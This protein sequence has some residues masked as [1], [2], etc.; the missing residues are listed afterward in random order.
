MLHFFAP[1]APTATGN[2]NKI[3]NNHSIKYVENNKIQNEKL[4]NSIH[5][6]KILPFRHSPKFII[7]GT[8]VSPFSQAGLPS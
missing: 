7:V 5:G 4:L 1:G 3:L 2:E 6:K 8:H